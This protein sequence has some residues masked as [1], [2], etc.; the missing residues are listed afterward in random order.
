M[1]GIKPI[2]KESLKRKKS[3]REV[4]EQQALNSESESATFSAF[5]RTLHREEIVTSPRREPT[6]NRAGHGVENDT[7]IIHE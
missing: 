5:L 1:K 2:T 7:S 3:M 4:M 6:W